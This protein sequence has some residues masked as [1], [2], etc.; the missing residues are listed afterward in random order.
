MTEN[1][2][3]SIDVD[4]S[5]AT[6]AQAYFNDHAINLGG[7]GSLGDHLNLEI[8]LSVTSRGVG[9]GFG[10]TFVLGNTH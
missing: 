10:A 6:A 7:L 3:P 9:S 2:V 5:N 8:A 1:A 4:F